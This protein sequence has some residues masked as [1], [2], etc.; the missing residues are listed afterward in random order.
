MQTILRSVQVGESVAAY[1]WP[2]ILCSSWQ[3]IYIYAL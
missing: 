2:K 3:V 1:T